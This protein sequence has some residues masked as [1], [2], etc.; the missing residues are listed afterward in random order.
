MLR[1]IAFALL[2]S[3]ALGMLADPQPRPTLLRLSQNANYPSR[4][5]SLHEAFTIL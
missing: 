2:V 1:I 5:D 4:T 3:F